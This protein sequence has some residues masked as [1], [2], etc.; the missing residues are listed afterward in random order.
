MANRHVPS[1]AWI[2]TLIIGTASFELVRHVVM[3][4][5]N[6]NLAPTLILLG[7][8]TVPASFVIFVCGRR[9]DY[10]VSGGALAGIAL[11]GGVVGVAVA[12]TLEYDTLHRLHTLPLVGV[13]LIEETAKLILPSVFL[14]TSRNSRA[15]DGLLTGVASGAGFAVLETMGYAF[16]ELVNTKGNLADV[17][18]VLW[19]RG[20]LSPAAH[21][22]WTGLT[23]AALWMAVGRPDR[24]SIGGLVATFAVVVALHTFWDS[25]HGIPEYAVLGA[26][27]LGCLL[28]TINMMSKRYRRLL[29]RQP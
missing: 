2:V 13:A 11:L 29:P 20:L 23:A 12:G 15:A 4:T 24:R 6:P 17:D 18:G 22:T 3:A 1:W 19:W 28:T 10:R 21:M 26:A 14:L 8:V 9:I 25:A 16:V 5:A 27:S 7:A